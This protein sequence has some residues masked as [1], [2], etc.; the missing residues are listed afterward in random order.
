MR[1]IEQFAIGAILLAGLCSCESKQSEGKKPVRVKVMRVGAVQVIGSRGYSGTVEEESGVSL[2]FPMA[3]TVRQMAV[4]EGQMVTRGQL[5]AT[6]DATDQ[7][8]SL[9]ASRATTEQARQALHQARDAYNR[10]KGLYEGGVMTEAKWVEAQTTLREA[11]EALKSAQALER[12]PQKA[13]GDTRLRA[14][15]AGYV[16]HRAADPGQNVLPGAMVAELV[17]I[18][19]VKVKISVP[20]TDVEQIKKGETMLV[21]CGATGGT[22]FYGKVV[23]RGV[24]ADPLSRT[25]VVKLLVDNPQHQ[26]LPGMICD[27][28]SQFTRGETSVFV[29][30]EVVQLNPDN[31][32]FVWV[33]KDG[34]ATKRFIHFVADTSQGVRVNGGLEPG[35]ELI[36]EGQQMVSEGTRCEPIGQGDGR[37]T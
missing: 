37:P 22:P 18:D 28:Y 21:K 15:F 23:E 3:G 10:A 33:V 32:M 31:R 12:V 26:L 8:A 1:K 17:H 11:E 16:A 27:V 29:P 30:A 2:S 6:L 19:R 14:P 13:Q 36:V 4:D 7:S 20:E 34:R 35:D 5:V 24:D 25:Y 9:A